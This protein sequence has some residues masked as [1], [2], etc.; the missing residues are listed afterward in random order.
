MVLP[1]LA[2]GG[3]SIT[4]VEALKVWLRHVTCVAQEGAEPAL[5]KWPWVHLFAPAVP[6]STAP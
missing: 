1:Q 5:P 3:Q 2:R 4:V 6:G